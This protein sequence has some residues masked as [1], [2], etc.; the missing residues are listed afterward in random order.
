MLLTFFI[1][2]KMNFSMMFRTFALVGLFFFVFCPICVEG[3]EPANRYVLI[4]EVYNFVPPGELLEEV[5]KVFAA[6]GKLCIGIMPVIKNYQ[7]PA[8]NEFASVINYAQAKGCHVFFDLPIVN[9][10]DPTL[11]DICSI[12]DENSKI[13]RDYGIEIEGLIIDDTNDKLNGI[14]DGLMGKYSTFSPDEDNLTKV[15]IDGQSYATITTDK[16]HSINIS[17]KKK[18]I[19]ED[20]DY[21]RNVYDRISI[22]LEKTNSVLMIVVV[23]STIIFL[24]MI[25][26]A[27]V[28]NRRN[29]V[30][31]KT[32]DDNN[33][34]EK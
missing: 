7:Y 20:F 32:I 19:P 4:D 12:I 23:S 13:Y 18:K 14:K 28:L 3:K 34:E 2:Q 6:Q 24:G 5:N 8:F 10:S 1:K 22:S 33:G 29:F 9:V 17:Q 16:L 26:Y 21:H 30:G 31:K 15:M 27:R 25:I 11:E